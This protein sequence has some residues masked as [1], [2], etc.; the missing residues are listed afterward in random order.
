VDCGVALRHAED[1]VVRQPVHSS[2]RPPANQSVDEPDLALSIPQLGQ[3]ERV[4]SRDLD[5]NPSREQPP[6]KPL[7]DDQTGPV[8]A[9]QRVTETDDEDSVLSAADP[10]ARS[11][12]TWTEQEM[13]GS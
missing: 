12:T 11:R 10:Q 9:R 7:G 5:P 4:R 2:G 1:L 3:S 8:V 6:R 13:Q